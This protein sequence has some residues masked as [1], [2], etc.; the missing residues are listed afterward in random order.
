MEVL[1]FVNHPS[2]VPYTNDS[3]EGAMEKDVN[4]D[5]PFLATNTIDFD[6]DVEVKIKKLFREMKDVRSAPNS[7]H[8]E[9]TLFKCNKCMKEILKITDETN[10]IPKV[11]LDDVCDVKGFKII[12]KIYFG[13]SEDMDEYVNLS[14][15]LQTR[16]VNNDVA[17]LK[18]FNWRCMCGRDSDTDESYSSEEEVVRP[19]PS[20]SSM[21]KDEMPEEVNKS[22]TVGIVDISDHYSENPGRT[23]LLLN[24]N[25]EMDLIDFLPVA[26]RK[27]VRRYS[28]YAF[29]VLRCN[30]HKDLISEAEPKDFV[31]KSNKSSE[32]KEAMD[33]LFEFLAKIDFE[34]EDPSWSHEMKHNID[35]LRVYSKSNKG[36]ISSE[37]YQ[38]TWE[39]DSHADY[40]KPFLDRMINAKIL[41]RRSKRKF[42]SDN[43]SQS[44]T[45]IDSD[46]DHLAELNSD[47]KLIGILE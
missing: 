33:L 2:L 31:K 25:V 18:E 9:E 43:S 14:K 21:S 36:R 24:N 12:C 11:F 19:G 45:D 46:D 13:C 32:G 23:F 47:D 35:S 7:I 4:S 17:I 22:P 40:Y 8:L 10:S 15:Q 41:E 27:E 5:N 20:Q 1:Q 44:D 16:L 6:R 34:K 38:S 26:Y 29:K 37:G 30:R 42:E 3:D 28:L 39:K